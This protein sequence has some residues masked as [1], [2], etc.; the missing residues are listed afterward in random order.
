LYPVSVY[1]VKGGVEKN[2]TFAAFIEQLG[3]DR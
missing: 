1:G 3:Q 2:P